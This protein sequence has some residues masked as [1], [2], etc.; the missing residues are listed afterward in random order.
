MQK[1]RSGH[2]GFKYQGKIYC[3]GGD[4]GGTVESFDLAKYKL[5]PKEAWKIE[6]MLNYKLTTRS[7]KAHMRNFSFSQ[8]TVIV[9]DDPEEK[10]NTIYDPDYVVFGLDN[11]RKIIKIKVTG[12]VY[13]M[14]AVDPPLNL[15]MLGYMGGCKVGE[16]L[17]FI[18]GGLTS[19]RQII[20]RNSYLYNADSNTVNVKALMFDKR[21][22]FAMACIYPYV[23]AIGGR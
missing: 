13:Q 1:K 14:E 9:D 11:Y 8:P 5:N 20:G 21:Y 19:T 16:K 12:G 6:E 23:Y 10:E 7:K 17:Y 4:T 3:M 18:A 2:K 15:A 22:T